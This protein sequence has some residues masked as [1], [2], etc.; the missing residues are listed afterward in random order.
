M[1]HAPCAS[2]APARPA[3][4]V[5]ASLIVLAALALT[6]C[7]KSPKEKLAGKWTGDRIENVSARDAS[8]AA[9]WV[10]GTTWE[11]SG[12]KMT[13]AIPAEPPRSGSY[14]VAKVEGDKVTL[15]IARPDGVTTDSAVLTFSDDKTLR[16][17]IG[18]SREIV[19]SKTE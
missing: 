1:P 10:K 6:A 12:E 19:L 2:F 15:S 18:E 8:R 16:W 13:V 9:A 11:F 4:L 14:K 3:R 17:D 7:S 5:A